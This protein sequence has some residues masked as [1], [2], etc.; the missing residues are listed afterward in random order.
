[1]LISLSYAAG[2]DYSDYLKMIG[3]NYSDKALAQVQSFK[4]PKVD[5]EL[6][7]STGN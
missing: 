2:L 5:E 3:M 6:F 1:M 4:Y 7:I